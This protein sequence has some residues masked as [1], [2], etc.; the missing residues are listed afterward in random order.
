[1]NQIHNT[2][3]KEVEK[4]KHHPTLEHNKNNEPNIQHHHKMLKNKATQGHHPTLKH[5]KNNHQELKKRTMNNTA[6]D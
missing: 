1:M 2:T 4:T 5:N 6:L 3:K